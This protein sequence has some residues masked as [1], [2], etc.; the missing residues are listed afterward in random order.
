MVDVT[1]TIRTEYEARI[2][3]LQRE[4]KRLWIILAA[5]VILVFVL[6]TVPRSAMGAGV[7]ELVYAADGQ[8]LPA[9]NEPMRVRIPSS[10]P[11]P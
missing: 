6:V 4:N 5:A 7:A 2:A 8:R 3:K 10:A 9:H 1:S 11:T